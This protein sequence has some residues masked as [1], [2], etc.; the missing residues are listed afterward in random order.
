MRAAPSADRWRVDHRSVAVLGVVTIVAYGS[1]YYAFG[2]LL[3][4][5]L[6]D[7]GWGESTVAASFAAGV[8][9]NGLASIAG[10]RALDRVGSRIVLLVGGLTGATAM[11]VTSLAPDALTFA[12][13]AAAAMGLLGGC[14]FYHITMT[15]AARLNP[16]HSARAIAVLTV[17]GAFASAIYL[18]ATAALVARHD[19]RV[20]VRLLAAVVIVVFALAALVLRPVRAEPA[21]GPPSIRRVLVST[22]DRPA[23]RA[24]TTALALGW[25][26][27]STILVYQVPVMTAAGLP[28]ATAATVAGFRGLAQTA[29]R[30]PLGP[31][32][33]RL[34]PARSVSIALASIA[35]GGVVLAFAGRLGPALA[36]ALL[37]GFGIGAM[38]PLQG[39][40]IGE[41]FDRETMGVT[42]GAYNLI[43]MGGGAAGPAVA[44]LLADATGS[45]RPVTVVIIACAAGASILAL[46]I[47][48]TR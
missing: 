40:V 41:L 13:S 33:D 10:G 42:M 2:V 43:G 19:W 47:G 7:T 1:W 36:F 20:T 14:G 22:V 26:A 45:R 30:V 8:V 18:P 23:R 35:A 17:W 29:G 39:I 31:I 38:S 24:F 34:G 46:R 9:A 6:A 48:R 32:V 16:D 11:V 3:D 5:I 15:C 37:A 27:M 12:V 21:E 4:P 25:I 44:G 28:L